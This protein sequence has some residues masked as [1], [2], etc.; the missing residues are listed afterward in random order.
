V[1]SDNP[2]F[3]S[4]DKIIQQILEG[5]SNSTAVVEVDRALAIEYAIVNA[6]PGDTILIAGEGHEDYQQVGQEK[7]SFNDATQARLAMAKRRVHD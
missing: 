4:P 2:R 6:E 7:L 1:T 3:E 5:M